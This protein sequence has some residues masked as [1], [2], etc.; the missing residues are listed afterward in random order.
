MSRS[1]EARSTLT[2][3][4]GGEQGRLSNAVIERICRPNTGLFPAPEEIKFS[5]SCPD[6]AYMCKHV[7]AVLYGVGAANPN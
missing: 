6:W 3:M 2:A 5:C 7:A 1:P 4:S